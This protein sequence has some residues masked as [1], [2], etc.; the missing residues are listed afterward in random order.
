[1]SPGGLK[2]Q[3]SRWKTP[4]KGQAVKIVNT[5]NHCTKNKHTINLG[6][7][8][9]LSKKVKK[10]KKK[11]IFHRV[12]VRLIMFQSRGDTGVGGQEEDN[13][14]DGEATWSSSD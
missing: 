2:K 10:K 13:L 14:W 5:L 4:T 3:M 7:Y 8:M 11:R 1:M 9:E 6:Q 12:G